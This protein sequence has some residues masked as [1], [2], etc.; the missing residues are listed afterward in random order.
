MGVFRCP[1]HGLSFIQRCCEHITVALE[2]DK[3]ERTNLVVDGADSAVMLCDVC[4][5]KALKEIGSA[6]EEWRE[7]KVVIECGEH[8][9]TWFSRTGQ[10]NLLESIARL[11]SSTR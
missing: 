9:T 6:T 8:A 3:L 5:L 10:G 2:A 7:V 11:K 4:S 1:D